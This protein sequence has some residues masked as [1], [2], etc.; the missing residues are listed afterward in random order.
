MRF[1]ENYYLHYPKV[2]IGHWPPVFYLIQGMWTLLFSTS[3]ASVMVFVAVLAALIALTLY[4]ILE[5]EFGG[6]LALAAGLVFLAISTV[7]AQTGMVM[8]DIPVALFSLLAA[9]WPQCISLDLSKQSV[10]STYW[11]LGCLPRSPS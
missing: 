2:A 8:A 9:Y 7:Q 3:R 11:L 6:L 10:E 5:A 4:R 1:A